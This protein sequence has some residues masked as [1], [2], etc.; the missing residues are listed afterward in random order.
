MTA[1]DDGFEARTRTIRLMNPASAIPDAVV[2][3][4]ARSAF[5]GLEGPS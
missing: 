3:A 5:T 2:Y 4:V 1:N